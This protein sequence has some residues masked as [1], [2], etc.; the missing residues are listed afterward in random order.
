MIR[1]QG[2][3]E[4]LGCYCGLFADVT[5]SLGEV[6]HPVATFP[7]QGD[8]VQAIEPGGVRCRQAQGDFTGLAQVEIAQRRQHGFQPPVWQGDLQRAGAGIVGVVD[9]DQNLFVVAALGEQGLV[10][11]FRVDAQQVEQDRQ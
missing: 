10:E 1:A 2:G 5:Q 8:I 3:I 7:A 6:A 4:A 9:G 11:Q